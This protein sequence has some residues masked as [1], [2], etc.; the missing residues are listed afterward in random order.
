MRIIVF[1]FVLF[2]FSCKSVSKEQQFINNITGEWLV[3]YPDHQLKNE[4]QRKLYGKIQDSI[5]SLKGLKLVS[6]AENR[7]F[8][9]V[10]NPSSNGRWDT[11]AMTDVNISEAG[12]GFENYKTKFTVFDNDIL[13]LTET[14]K[15]DGEDIRL[16]WHFKKIDKNNTEKL[17]SKEA[18]AWR[19]KPVNAET[20]A[21][22]KKRLAAALYY[23]ADYF[24]L[25]AEES[26]YFIG[27]RII[28]PFAFYQHAIGTR[29]LDPDSDFAGMFYDN[30]Q[31]EKAYEYL[32]DI[33]SI[34]KNDFSKKDNYVKGYATHMKAMADRIVTLP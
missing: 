5:V 6:F 13:Q 21:E 1:L 32:Q 34:L 16:I 15:Y 8:R 28:L 31:A 11:K 17:F 22:I 7:I 3:L 24:N 26:T 20:D 2:S 29:D 14:V 27:K 10:D 18:N 4:K 23:Y 9:Q 25:V 33:I 19:L 12:E 30:E